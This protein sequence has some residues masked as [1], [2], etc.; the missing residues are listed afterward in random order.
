MK[1]LTSVSKGSRAI[2]FFFLMWRNVHLYEVA[3]SNLSHS[4]VVWRGLVS[5]LLVGLFL[6]N[7]AGAL[8]SFSPS[9]THATKICCGNIFEVDWRAFLKIDSTC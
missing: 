2:I 7:M 9:T 5:T 6:A 1:L 3:V 4:G 8:L